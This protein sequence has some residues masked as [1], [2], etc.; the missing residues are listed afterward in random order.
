MQHLACSSTRGV[1]VFVC[2]EARRYS[3]VDGHYGLKKD[4]MKI[5]Q[6]AAFPNEEE[7]HP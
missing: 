6:E 4:V 2:S 5:H 1:K 7:H 3:V